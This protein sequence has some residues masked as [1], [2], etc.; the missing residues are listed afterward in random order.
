MIYFFSVLNTETGLCLM[1]IDHNYLRLD[2]QWVT[3]FISAL[4]VFSKECFLH[5]S[6]KINEIVFNTVI[7]RLFEFFRELEIVL[8]SDRSDDIDK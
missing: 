3:G 1:E 8:F 2:S 7:L 5:R 4:N 6:E